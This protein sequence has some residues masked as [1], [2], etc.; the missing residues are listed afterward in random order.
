MEKRL[1]GVLIPEMIVNHH[2]AALDESLSDLACQTKMVI[3]YILPLKL[4]EIFLQLEFIA[5]WQLVQVIF[6]S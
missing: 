2:K 6:K 4:I 1:K 3:Q 5:N